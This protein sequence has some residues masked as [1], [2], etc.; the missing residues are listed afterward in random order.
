MIICDDILLYVTGTCEKIEPSS[1]LYSIAATFLQSFA[2][3]PKIIQCGIDSAKPAEKR[4]GME[5]KKPPKIA[6]VPTEN[7]LLSNG[8]TVPFWII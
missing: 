1:I 6:S 3:V 2:N 7:H 8:N 5:D 4:C